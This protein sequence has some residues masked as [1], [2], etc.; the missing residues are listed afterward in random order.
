MRPLTSS[1]AINAVSRAAPDVPRQSANASATGTAITP[2]WPSG[3]TGSKS[4]ALQQ[5]VLASAARSSATRSPPPAMRDCGSGD[6]RASASAARPLGVAAPTIMQPRQSSN[7]I[8]AK[9]RTSAD[10]SSNRKPST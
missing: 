3:P 4:S 6:S 10:T 7:M 8:L 5:I 9:R 1:P 2:T